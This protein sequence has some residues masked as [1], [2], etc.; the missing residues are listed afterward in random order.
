[1]KL[2]CRESTH[3][4]CLNCNV[5]FEPEPVRYADH[6]GFCRT[7]RK[8]LDKLED[9]KQVVLNW[10][11]LHWEQLEEQAIAETKTMTAQQAANRAQLHAQAMNAQ[12]AAMVSAGMGSLF[13]GAIIR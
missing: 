8:P 5:H 13:G 2:F 10:A 11:T 9:R 12:Q 6:Q 7:C 3:S 1:M 4:V